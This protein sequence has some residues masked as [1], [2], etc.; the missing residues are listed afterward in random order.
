MDEEKREEKEK[1]LGNWEELT[2]H[3]GGCR[4]G[5]GQEL[6]IW[7]RE[8]KGEKNWLA[9]GRRGEAMAGWGCCGWVSIGFLGRGGCMARKEKHPRKKKGGRERGVGFLEKG[10]KSCGWEKGV[11]LPFAKTKQPPGRKGKKVRSGEGGGG[12]RRYLS[13]QRGAGKP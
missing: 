9:Q 5:W 13:I 10:T 11:R 4:G 7:D 8:V 6:A 3:W 1:V 2:K 12:Q